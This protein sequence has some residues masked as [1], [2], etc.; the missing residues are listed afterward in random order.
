MECARFM[1]RKTEADAGTPNPQG[2]QAHGVFPW[3]WS[4]KLRRKEEG[5]QRSVLLC[6]GGCSD[7]GHQCAK[8][9]SDPGSFC[10]WGV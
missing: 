9:S 3:K 7:V 6:R 10:S 4:W 1:V 8:A 5:A 2:E